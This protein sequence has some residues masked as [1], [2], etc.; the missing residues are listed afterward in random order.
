[1]ASVPRAELPGHVPTIGELYATCGAEF[2]LSVDV[3]DEGAAAARATPRSMPPSIRF[4]LLALGWDAQ[5][6]RTIDELLDTGID[7][8]FSDHV[9]RLMGRIHA[10]FPA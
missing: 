8:V 6:D 10:R 4:E 3:K 1:M 9:D 7:G 2:E 5:F